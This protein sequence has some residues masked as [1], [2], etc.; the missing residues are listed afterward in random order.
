MEG[1]GINWVHGFVFLTAFT[2]MEFVAWFTHK[3]IMH[4]FLWFL[5][6]DHHKRE[7]RGFFERND[8]FFL[9]FATPGMLCLY[10][11]T[12]HGFDLLFWAGVGIT[13]Y[14]MTYFLVHD[15]FIHQRLRWFRN[16]KNPYLRAIRKAHKRHHRHLQKED[17]E[18]FGM[19]WVPPKYFKQEFRSR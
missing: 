2:G 7:T 5:H 12:F 11:G 18:C 13:A 19:L 9:T 1:I 15:V 14:G 3:Y 8:W 16:I 10:T 4:G 6:R 17:G